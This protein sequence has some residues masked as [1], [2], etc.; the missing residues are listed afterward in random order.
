MEQFLRNYY[1]Q[2]HFN[3]MPAEVR[4]RFFDW[5][6]NDTLTD[7]MRNWV[8]ERLQ[9][10][11][12]PHADQL[13]VDRDGNYVPNALP[14]PNNNADLSED[15]AR[16]LFVVFQQAFSKMAANLGD[17]DQQ[18]RNFVNRYFRQHGQN[19]QR[20]FQPSDATPE[21]ANGI[22]AIL[23][24]L[25]TPTLNLKG[26]VVANAHDTDGKPL[27]NSV[28]DLDRLLT[29]CRNREYNTN[30][31][32][33]N[34]I[35]NVARTL[36]NVIGLSWSSSVDTN[37]N[38]YRALDGIRNEIANVTSNDAFALNP[39]RIDPDALRDFRDIYA[40]AAYDNNT[41]SGLLQTL[42]FNKTI[43]DQFA[44]YDN[45]TITNQINRAENNI[46]WQ[47][48][49]KD[50]YVEP[51][52]DD[53]LTPLQRIQEWAT[54][55]YN[56]TL[57]KYEELR[58]ATNLFSQEAKD[59]FKAVDK[60]KIKPSDGLSAILEK[61]GK[62]EGNLNNPVARQHFQWFTETMEPLLKSMPK[63][64]EGAWKDARQMQ[65]IIS[66]IM[67]KATDPKN[68][69]P[70][71]MDKAK[72]AMEIMTAMKYGMATSKIM[73]AI[74]NDKELFNIF[75]NKDLSWNKSEG[76]K[77]VTGALDN[78]VRAA[79]LGA[80]YAVTIVKN[81]IKLSGRKYN[82]RDNQDENSVLAARF[83]QENTNAQQALQN[84]NTVDRG[85]LNHDQQTLQGLNTG[86]NAV[87][88][89]TVNNLTNNVL[90]GLN[91]TLQTAR[92]A[93]D[94]AQQD[95]N[96]VNN[97]TQDARNRLQNNAQYAQQHGRLTQEIN[98]ANQEITRLE[99]EIN[100]LPAGP[101][102]DARRET[103]IEQLREQIR[104][105]DERT[106]ELTNL[107]NAH[108]AYIGPN[109]QFAQDQLAE[110]RYNNF[111]NALNTAQGA[112]DTAEQQYN[113]LNDRIQQYN[114]A[115]AEVTELTRAIQ[116]RENA[117]QHWDQHNTNRIIELE[118][119]WNFLQD[120]TTSWS[121]FQHRAQARFDRNK[122]AMLQT[123]INRH[124][125]A[126]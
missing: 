77:F 35:Q 38:E 67:L 7:D 99:T 103:L 79:F 25:D 13:L 124:G 93:R 19:Q 40:G 10:Q 68:D 49:T 53:V 64:I 11:P 94:R 15:N 34:R 78:T 120:N 47:D 82:N 43:R 102:G 80:G 73:D 105:H 113:D 23:R 21:C 48:K 36:E 54:D 83:R 115:T 110:Q 52:V 84:Q 44:K 18:S 56:D 116:D 112:F 33:Q 58:G 2:L 24:V 108:N 70:H 76:I 55:T 57:K 39:A 72:T 4:A 119:Y 29:Q 106:Q 74:K 60:E 107:D 69:D 63:A 109:G 17:L 90:P 5:V 111:Q 9:H 42:Y 8:R 37:S 59:I 30:P 97:Q 66:Q 12:A 32:V 71:A 27:F 101:V 81:K 96:T 75:S 41:Q 45:G 65:A 122:Q 86:P 114:D 126:A 121:L 89:N 51:L 85:R 28:T 104:V 88:A 117:L 118:N 22:D 87:N 26:Y 20:L 100:N 31:D 62:I 16:R 1:R 6:R 91:Q 50:N 46:N 61:K 98:Q 125:M 95:F 123:Y 92:G 14:I 3:S